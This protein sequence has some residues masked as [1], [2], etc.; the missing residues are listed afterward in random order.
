M[1]EQINQME[2]MERDYLK[3]YIYWAERQM[4]IE[5]HYYAPEFGKV[6]IELNYELQKMETN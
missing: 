2:D 4:E 6:E 1:L 3:D 5:Q